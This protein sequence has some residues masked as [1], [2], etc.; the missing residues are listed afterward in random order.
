MMERIN[1]RRTFGFPVHFAAFIAAIV[2]NSPGIARATST[3]C[4]T[5]T[6]CAEYI[7]TSSGVAIHGEANGGIGIRG[8]SVSNTGFY[9]ASGSGYFTSPG[10]NGE[11]TN[12]SGNDAAGAFGLTAFYEEP[13]GYGVLAYGI[14]YGVQGETEAA[15]N[16]STPGYGL[17][18]F[19][20]SGSGT[21]NAAIFGESE[22]GT[23]VLAEVAGTPTLGLIGEEQFGIYAVAEPVDAGLKRAVAV[24]AES[25]SYPLEAQNT[26]DKSSIDLVEGG[27]FIGA[28]SKKGSFTVTDAGSEALSGTLT[29]SK[30][31]YVR[32]AGG[33]G[34]ARTAYGTRSTAPEIEDV[35]EGTLSNGRAYVA[36]DAAFG[37][38]IDMRR[39][40]HVFLTPEGDCNGLY[41]TQKSPGGFVVHELRGGRSNLAFEY[42]IV[43]KP[44]DENGARLAIAGPLP[45]SAPSARFIGGHMPAPLTAEQRAQRELGPQAYARA[46]RQLHHNI[47]GT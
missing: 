29:T 10:V 42:R 43:A 15:A 41:V 28:S 36:V 16:A 12:E 6:V 24:E 22:D 45:E 8:T 32:T 33:S 25:D 1:M 11:S 17:F 3:T 4:A 40:Y 37:D 23:G 7:D 13:P 35:G 9:G 30:G 20:D 27:N 44:L 47:S 21:K 26:Y 38:T 2:A 31:T 19:D 46:L 39:A 5:S 18:G 34:I 14:R